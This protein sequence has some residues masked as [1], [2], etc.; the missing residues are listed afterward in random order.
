MVARMFAVTLAV[1]TVAWLAATFAVA[2]Q[3]IDGTVEKAGA[4]KI[5][6][7]DTA[8]TVHKFAVDAAAKISLDGK[9]VKLDDLKGGTSATVLTESK[10]NEN[11]AVMIT[12]RSKL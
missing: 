9:T 11:V 12:A 5:E 10:N 6:I 3:A 7:R 1:V 8:G 4:G 2:G